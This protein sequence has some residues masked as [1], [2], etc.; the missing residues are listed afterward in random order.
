MFDTNHHRAFEKWWEYASKNYVS[1]NDDKPVAVDLYYDPIVDEH[2]LHG[3]MGII[4]PAWYFAP[5]INQLAEVG[6]NTAARASGA[7]GDGPITG[8]DDPG[9]A[10]MLLQLAGEFADSSTKQKL[11]EAAEE[12][13]EP[14]RDQ[15]TGEFT[16]GLKLNELHPR[17]QWNAR[18]M[19]GWVCTQGAW[20]RIF[21]EP[22]LSKFDE[23]TVE[24]I[25]FPM[26]A[27]SEARWDGNTL[28]IAAHPQNS[29]AKGT[30]TM[31]RLANVA[32]SKGW[33]LTKPSG[34]KVLLDG[35][36][37]HV[38]FEITVDNQ[39]VMLRQEESQ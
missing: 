39:V 24:G 32:S 1:W 25:N 21:N 5:Q 36:G 17:G 6:W 20:S 37:D 8:L 2:V 4:A 30:V 29:E 9:T 15:S 35:R 14:T 34:D 13:I 10:T 23:P 7:F 3:A 16:F 38:L 33:V 19:A 18:M 27:L 11:W 22:N 31:A 28:H 26:V 12:H